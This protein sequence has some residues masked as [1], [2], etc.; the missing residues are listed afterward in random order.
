LGNKTEQ[1]AKS[2]IAE[3]RCLD[4]LHAA[5]IMEVRILKK[6]M[7]TASSLEKKGA[8]ES[9]SGGGRVS[10]ILLS[11]PGILSVYQLTLQVDV[12][13]LIQALAA[14]RGLSPIGLRIGSRRARG[15]SPRPGVLF[16]IVKPIL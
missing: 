4:R 16:L 5:G 2:T 7:F 3:N 1:A 13:K 9:D 12:K 10:K 8:V 6:R 15:L 11:K 14:A